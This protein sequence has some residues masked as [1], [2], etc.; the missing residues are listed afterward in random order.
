M[1]NGTKRAQRSDW[2]HLELP[3]EAVYDLI[4]RTSMPEELREEAIR[5]R[6]PER[7][8]DGHKGS[9][10][11]TFV[12]GGSRGLTGA[13]KL[14][15]LAAARSGTGL[16]TVG[17]P[18]PL[19][20]VYAAALMEIMSVL[21]PATQEEGLAEEALAPALEFAQKCDAVAVGPGLGRQEAS[22][23]FV[24][25]FVRRCPQ[26]VLID[27][28]ALFALSKDTQP[29]KDAHGP[30][31]LTPHPG[32]MGRLT[33][34]SP[35]DVQQHREELAAAFAAEHRCVLVLKGHRTLI[36]GPDGALFVNPTGNDGMATGGTG[37][38]LSGLIAGLLAQGLTA[39]DA[40]VVGVYVHGVAG[41][42][43]AMNKTRRGMIAGDLIDA[44]PQAWR[45][46]EGEEKL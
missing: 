7:P 40:A 27:A 29:L 12:L 4:R 24:R 10:G 5:Q 41:D 30:R 36:A 1:E 35:H 11:H 25:A 19:G 23:R 42:L 39:L 43:A 15:A 2:Q 13:V 8:A 3:P 45:S 16:V 31:I 37:D 14:A 6:I 33:G 26:P 34:T 38:V 20:D 44:L 32:E 18:K 9:F 21:L 28:D 17:I 22:Q 46:I